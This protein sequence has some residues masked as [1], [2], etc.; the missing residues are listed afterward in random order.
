[1]FRYML[2]KHT[3]RLLVVKI[4]S[5]A[6][7]TKNLVPVRKTWGGF[8]NKNNPLTKVKTLWEVSRPT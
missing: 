6:M 1:M 2:Y 7:T 5:Q 4:R 8:F 3:V